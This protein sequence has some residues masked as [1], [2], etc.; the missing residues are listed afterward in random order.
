[1]GLAREGSPVSR[2][3]WV[4]RS[5]PSD[6][7]E[8]GRYLAEARDTSVPVTSQSVA[9]YLD[10]VDSAGAITQD[11]ELFVSVQ[12]DATRARRAIKRMGGGDDGACAVLCRELEVFAERLV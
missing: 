1:A 9:S 5:L 11:H 3:Q 2:V 6:G 8:V 4:E 12:I 10:L 7:D